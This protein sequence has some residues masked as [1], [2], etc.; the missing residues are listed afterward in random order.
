MSKKNK[1]SIIVFIIIISFGFSDN[2]QLSGFVG[3]N[4]I[5][6]YGST[7]DYIAGENDFP[8]TPAHKVLFTGGAV[9]YY[10]MENFG[11]EF[12]TIY[13]FSTKLKLEDPSDKDSV[14]INSSKNLSLLLEIFYEKQLGKITPYLTMGGGINIINNRSEIVLST[15]GYEI[16]FS[17]ADRTTDPVFS[18]GGG[19]KLSIIKY[20]GMK[21]GVKYNLIFSKQTNISNLNIFGGFILSF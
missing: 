17:R 2:L 13:N 3:L 21:L 7:D 4:S 10:L 14:E 12:S 8:I 5:Y 9:S 19:V 1:I 6:Q 18:F 16:E 20:L 15:Y 11:F